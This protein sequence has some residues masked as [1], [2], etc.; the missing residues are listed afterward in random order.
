[1]LSAWPRWLVRPEPRDPGQV[2]RPST[3]QTGLAPTR[4]ESG[5]NSLAERI[6]AW[7]RRDL[8]SPSTLRLSVV[9]NALSARTLGFAPVTD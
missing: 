1:M 6:E 5:V 2:G 7:A 4:V 3:G 9:T 8:S